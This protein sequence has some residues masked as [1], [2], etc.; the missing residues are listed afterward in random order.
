MIGRALS[1]QFAYRAALFFVKASTLLLGLYMLHAAVDKAMQPGE[2]L[3]SLE[4]AFGAS[5]ST[6][7]F[8]VL[9]AIEI[10][11]AGV[12]VG[13]VQRTFALAGLAIV[14]V[15]F[16]GWIGYLILADAPVS[17][18]CQS[19]SNKTSHFDALGRTSILFLW[20]ST[21]FVCAVLTARTADHHHIPQENP[22]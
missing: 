8:F 6:F 20:C 12:L 4:W 22:T 14:L 7:L 2:T 3:S 13:G 21:A 10:T 19:R 11:L 18:G 5:R 15:I 17:C 9:I 1:R 16:L